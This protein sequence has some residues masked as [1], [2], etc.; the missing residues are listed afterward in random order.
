LTLH[1]A[2]SFVYPLGRSRLL[3]VALFL[4]W[5]VAANVTLCW[6]YFSAAGDWRPMLGWLSLL[7]SAVFMSTGWRRAPVGALGWDG[8]RWR[9]ESPVYRGGSA[10]DAPIV[11]MDL[12]HALL[13][14][15]DNRAGAV[16]WLWA[17]R[18]SAP[19][20]WLALRRAVYAPGRLESS[21]GEHADKVRRSVALE[22][23]R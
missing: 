9:W 10:L 14:R 15:M 16:W 20:R 8:Q 4:G 21:S 7:I 13:L 5:I 23:E 17:E 2:P 6:A 3:G 12:Q 19:A 11:V 22:L 18:S 1:S